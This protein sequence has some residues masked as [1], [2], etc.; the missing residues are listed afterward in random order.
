MTTNQLLLT[1]NGLFLPNQFTLQGSLAITDRI[2]RNFIVFDDFN[3]FFSFIKENCIEK[4]FVNDTIGKKGIYV[5]YNDEIFITN[6][7]KLTYSHGIWMDDFVMW[8]QKNTTT[9]LSKFVN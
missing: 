8:E 1:N 7:G 4:D 2:E 9:F 3:H 6:F 5:G